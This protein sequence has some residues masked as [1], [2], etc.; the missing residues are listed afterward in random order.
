MATLAKN[1]VLKMSDMAMS[2]VLTQ[3]P[4]VTV[5]KWSGR[6]W[7]TEKT[8]SHDSATPVETSVPT[9]YSNGDV[10]LTIDWDHTNAQHAQIKAYSL[11]GA[12]CDFEMIQVDSAAD[13]NFTG[14]ITNL[15]FDT[16]VDGLLKA[17]VTILVNGVFA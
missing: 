8:T 14:Y 4:N 10:Q 16:P 7:N 12:P 11:T 5:M 1:T 6:K 9:I 13:D 15:T 3:I 17:N 2:P